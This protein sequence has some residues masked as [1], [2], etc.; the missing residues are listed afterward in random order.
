MRNLPDEVISFKDANLKQAL[1]RYDS[2]GDGNITKGELAAV[3]YLYLD[4][5][6]I[7]NLSGIEY[8]VNAKE[9][10]MAA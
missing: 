10:F 3:T 4:E 2:N 7:S 5:K 9:L 1:L 8:A 6:N